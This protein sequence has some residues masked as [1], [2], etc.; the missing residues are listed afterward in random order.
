[1]TLQD[2]E[3][4]WED[5]NWRYPGKLGPKK[6]VNGVMVEGKVLHSKEGAEGK[7]L[8]PAVTCRI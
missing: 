4:L 1:M 8:I 5:A 2:A 7:F 6:K 3:S